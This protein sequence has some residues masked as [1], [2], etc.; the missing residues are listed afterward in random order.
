MIKISGKI[1][2]EEVLVWLAGVFALGG[3]FFISRLGV[4][5]L[6]APRFAP[7]VMVLGYTDR[8]EVF[9]ALVSSV[10]GN[11]TPFR[12]SVTRLVW[13]ATDFATVD[14]AARLLRK[15]R[16]LLPDLTRR[17][18]EVMEDFLEARLP[19]GR[20]RRGEEYLVE[21]ALVRR[22]E[23]YDAMQ[24]LKGERRT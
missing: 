15:N 18:L 8:E 7:G 5:A 1:T 12:G 4:T 11:I 14:L 19:R 24:K 2:D 9:E 22:Q 13:K 6:G 17:E 3:S 23:L 10:G 21:D 20:P 16:H